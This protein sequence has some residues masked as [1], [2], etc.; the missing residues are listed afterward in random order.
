VTTSSLDRPPIDNKTLQQGD[1]PVAESHSADGAAAKSSDVDPIRKAVEDGAAVSTGLWISYIFTLFYIAIAAGAVSHIDLLLESP[2]KLPFLGIELPLLAFFFLAPLLFL[3]AHAYTLV[4]FVML[5]KKATLFHAALYAQYPRDAPTPAERER[6]HE[7]RESIRRQLPSNI[8]VQVLAGARDVRHSGFGFLLRIIAWVTLVFAPVAL[9]FELQVQFL[10]FHHLLLT[11]EHRVALLL[12]MALIWWLWRKIFDRNGDAAAAG[13]RREMPVTI[14]G[15]VLS[16]L[17]VWLSCSLAT[18]PGEWQTFTAYRP[19]HAMLFHG[20]PNPSTHRPSSP[21]SNILVLPYLNV[22][23]ILKVDDPQK[24]DWR[25]HLLSLR[26]RDLRGAIFDEAIMERID[27]QSVQLQGASLNFVRMQASKL[28]EAKL[29]G[30]DFSTAQLQGASLLRAQ[31]QGAKLDGAG[32]QGAKV[33]VASL[34]GADLSNAQL[35]G[36]NFR[37]S[38]LRGADFTLAT[39]RGTSFANLPGDVTKLQ[40]ATFDQATLD[41]V[42][43]N[44]ALLWRASFAGTS[45][46]NILGTPVWTSRADWGPQSYAELRDSLSAVPRDQRIAA[47]Q[48]I[49]GIACAA[50]PRTPV[51]IVPSPLPPEVRG[52]SDDIKR[53]TVDRATYQKALAD[54][55]RDIICSGDRNSLAIF[56]SL[57]HLGMPQAAGGVPRPMGF[58]DTGG[59]AQPL[60]EYVM[61]DKCPMSSQLTLG[62]KAALLDVEKFSAQLVSNLKAGS[63]TPAK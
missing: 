39:L 14:V 61:S 49:E 59:E 23:D 52:W 47:L 38:D 43:L 58:L 3:V 10:P 21:F 25:E 32:L 57:V 2:V 5:G 29:Q 4:H 44:G 18:I 63:P 17:V 46:A 36:A 22:Y 33:E 12:D 51:C 48:R 55:Y 41:T 31:M 7:I 15:G 1:A 9:L 19:L 62:D 16:A 54:I 50:P 35:Q 11:W 28:D 13:H 6:N 42:N 20:F 53:A 45:S 56:R 40:G 27:A 8:F 26:G 60:A 24:T 30:A 34:V 37:N